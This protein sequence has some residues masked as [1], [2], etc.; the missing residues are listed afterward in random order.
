MKKISRRSINHQIIDIFCWKAAFVAASK[1]TLLASDGIRWAANRLGNVFKAETSAWLSGR[2]P[3][4]QSPTLK[5]VDFLIGQLLVSPTFFILTSC[6]AFI[7]FVQ[8]FER[9]TFHLANISC[10]Q[11]LISLSFCL[12]DSLFSYLSLS[13]TFLLAASFGRLFVRPSF[14]IWSTFHLAD[15][16]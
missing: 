12:T 1:Q 14:S 8:F 15:F 4:E 11:F 6:L 16:L 2:W 9:P 13:P 7:L 5:L 10:C 3:H